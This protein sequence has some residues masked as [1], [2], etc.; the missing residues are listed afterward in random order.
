MDYEPS[1]GAI[2]NARG[3]RQCTITATT[4]PGLGKPRDGPLPVQ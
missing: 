3:G 2:L 4:L 1:L